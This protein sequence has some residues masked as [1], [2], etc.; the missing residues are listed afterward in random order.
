MSPRD[1]ALYILSQEGWAC[2]SC[3]RRDG[4]L[5]WNAW[6]SNADPELD[7]LCDV[8]GD[9]TL[10]IGLTD[11]TDL[12]GNWLIHESRE[13]YVEVLGFDTEEELRS[14]YGLIEGQLDA[15]EGEA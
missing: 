8:L 11:A 2:E 3:G 9:V 4:P 5:G 14:V 15:L 1:E 12:L 6:M 7:D 10:Q 13:G